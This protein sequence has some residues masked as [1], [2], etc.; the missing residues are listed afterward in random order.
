MNVCTLKSNKGYNER[1]YTDEKNINI[2]FLCKQIVSQQVRVSNVYVASF[3]L[4]CLRHGRITVTDE[5]KRTVHCI[6]PSMMILE[7][8]QFINIM[9]QEVDGHLS[10]DVIDI[11]HSLL[12]IVHELLIDK[13]QTKNQPDE[14]PFRMVYIDNTPVIKEVF[15]LLKSILT[16][17]DTL[18]KD[19][20]KKNI[21]TYSLLLL[22]SVFINE[23]AFSGIINRSIKLS[24]KYKVYNLLYTKPDK[25]WKL[26]DVSSAIF[27]ST[28]S[29]KRKLATEGTTFS[30]LY[31]MARMNFASKL[32][33]TGKYSVTDVAALCGYDSVSYFIFC[34]K[35]QFD[36]TPSAFMKSM[37]H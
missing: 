29:L 27:M 23:S 15:E 30:E 36:I 13:L 32:L 16:G 17:D 28:S 25:Q 14:H 2:S 1:K 5:R 11:P 9:M 8:D 26:S 24:V 12:T 3:T 18:T 35:K 31:I 21:A 10:F 20:E 6:A 34:F 7:K 22:L 33:R 19:E 37:N 4:I